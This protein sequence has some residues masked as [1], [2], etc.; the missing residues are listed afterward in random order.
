MSLWS[1]FDLNQFSKYYSSPV[2]LGGLI[3]LQCFFLDWSDV[4]LRKTLNVCNQSKYPV[5][6]LEFQNWMHLKQ[7]KQKPRKVGLIILK[8][9]LHTVV[10]VVVVVSL[11]LLQAFRRR[12]HWLGS[13]LSGSCNDPIRSLSAQWHKMENKKMQHSWKCEQ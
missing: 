7:C 11:P 4:H 6:K 10:V 2:F 12:T 13:D 3:F 9:S 1:Q 8:Q 5:L